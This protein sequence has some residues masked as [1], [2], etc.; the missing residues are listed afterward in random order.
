MT[1]FNTSS[2][3]D[4]FGRQLRN[5]S[6]LSFEI[7][8]QTVKRRLNIELNEKKEAYNNI[9][10]TP[11]PL[12]AE[13]KKERDQVDLK[14]KELVSYLDSARTNAQ[15]IEDVIGEMIPR[16]N[17]AA[18]DTGANAEANFNAYRDRLNNRLRS[19][20]SNKYYE[21][22]FLDLTSSVKTLANPIGVGDYN[23]YPGVLERGSAVGHVITMPTADKEVIPGLSEG[24]ALKLGLL[25]SKM[26]IDFDRANSMLGQTVTKTD[27]NGNT[28]LDEKGQPVKVPVSGLVKRLD[29]LDKRIEKVDAEQ[30]LAVLK[31]AQAME[32][33]HDRILESLSLS[34]EFS[35][36]N[37]EAMA[38]RTSF[39]T[40]QK[41]SIMN[42][43]I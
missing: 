34:F 13:L 43:F 8:F 20:I 3:W 41:G 23:S 30:R 39:L 36:A 42:L 5:N 33:R 9:D 18:S 35:M 10:K 14:R 37:A 4:A 19:F 1:T 6:R 17:T 28:V 24:A 29:D 26:L 2:I 11:S 38:D 22:G 16:L 7:Q 32:K 12:L 15:K 31:E 21:E 27:A 40:P 25:R